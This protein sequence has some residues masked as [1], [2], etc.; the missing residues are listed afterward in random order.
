MSKKKIK[1]CTN[2]ENC[3]ALGEGDFEC[4]ERSNCIVMADYTPTDKF[5]VG[6]CPLWE[7]E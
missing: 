5:R 6:N 7:E 1:S 2:C 3:I 4:S